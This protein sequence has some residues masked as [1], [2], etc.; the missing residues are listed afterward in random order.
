MRRNDTVEII[1]WAV[2]CLIGLLILM[3]LLPYIILFLALCGA[4]YL[5]EEYCRNN[6]R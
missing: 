5:Y 2:G 3:K 1:C 4:Y 6:R